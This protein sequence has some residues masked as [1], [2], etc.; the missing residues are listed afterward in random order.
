M[1]CFYEVV[2]GLVFFERQ[3]DLFVTK[4]IQLLRLCMFQFVVI[5]SNKTT[6]RGSARFSI[7][8]L[9]MPKYYQIAWNEEFEF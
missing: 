4:F 1:R 7:E 8:G 2:L 3:Y 9:L 6:S 5:S